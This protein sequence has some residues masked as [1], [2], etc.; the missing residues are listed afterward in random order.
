MLRVSFYAQTL[1]IICSS[2]AHY[3]QNFIMKILFIGTIDGNSAMACRS[4]LSQVASSERL[5]R[6]F[7]LEILSS[8]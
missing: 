1:L 4:N 5:L 6:F 2:G 3:E 7:S 8:S